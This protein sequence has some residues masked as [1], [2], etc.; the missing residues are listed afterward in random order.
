MKQTGFEQ[1]TA[2]IKTFE[3]PHCLD[4][5][6]ASIRE[7]YPEMPI[8]VADDSRRPAVRN[9]V[10]YHVLPKDSGLSRGRNYLVKQVKTPYT[11][12]LDDDFCFI[13][14]TDIGKL[15]RAMK[16]GG[17]D[18]VGGRY[19]E[20][21]GVRN[22]QGTFKLS[23]GVLHYLVKS[24]GKK[25]GLPRYDIVNNF[26]LARTEALR[27]CRWDDRLK[28][29]G[30]HLDFFLQH[31]GKLKVAMHPGVFVYHTNDRS[32]ETY[33]K[34]RSRDRTT[35]KPM[36]MKKHG[37]K[38]IRRERGLFRPVRTVKKRLSRETR[39]LLRSGR[40]GA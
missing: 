23:R 15:L 16:A 33:V 39:M 26:F 5:L 34:F 37:I 22:S 21:K 8:I 29:G 6:I 9:D 28:T 4:R 20:P 13:R 19:L 36:F 24:R 3:R 31:K 27:R 40:K 35:F 2:I 14:E 38:K 1:V 11:L 30:Q 12:L 18:I 25:A 7:Y 32:S 10:E 17:F